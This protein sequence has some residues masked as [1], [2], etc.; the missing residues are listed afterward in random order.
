M[1]ESAY[2]SRRLFL[3]SAAV[4]GL[5][6]IVDSSFPDLF[7]QVDMDINYCSDKATMKKKADYVL[8][9]I[10]DEVKSAAFQ[11]EKDSSYKIINDAYFRIT[12][13][14]RSKTGGPQ[15]KIGETFHLRYEGG[16]AEGQK[17]YVDKSPRFTPK[18]D[19]TLY[20]KGEFPKVSLL[21]GSDGADNT[22]V[23]E[24]F[25][26]VAKRRKANQK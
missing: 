25:H 18:Q 2:N 11:V 15:P 26:N 22:F 5:S 1:S 9:V 13:I 10:V 8:D 24:F 3:K 21:C 23:N 7:G 14:K 12:G 19:V 20:L 4:L 16:E 6:E 17:Q